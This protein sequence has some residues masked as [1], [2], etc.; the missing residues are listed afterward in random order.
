LA[1]G[2]DGGKSGNVKREGELSGR[3]N[4]RGEHVREEYVQREN[5]RVPCQQALH[6]VASG[7]VFLPRD[8]CHTQAACKRSPCCRA[9][10]VRPSG[11]CQVLVLYRNRIK[12]IFKLFSP[13]SR[14]TILDIG[15][16]SR[17]FNTPSAFDFPVDIAITFGIEK[18]EWWLYQTVTKV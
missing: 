14:P 12:R 16:K 6:R 9:V 11:V 8:S 2:G 13:S 4:V 18:L 17:F 7:V 10:S 1:H 5:D 15:R 3:G